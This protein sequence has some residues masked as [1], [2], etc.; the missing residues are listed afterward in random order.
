MLSQEMGIHL[1]VLAKNGMIQIQE[2]I[3]VA[4]PEQCFTIA[5]LVLCRDLPDFVVCTAA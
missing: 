1:N 3:R 5:F 2:A 4:D